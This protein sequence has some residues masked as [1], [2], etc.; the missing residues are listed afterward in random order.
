MV[1]IPA[2]PNSPAAHLAWK[3]ASG[4]NDLNPVLSIR[5]DG[6]LMQIEYRDETM[7]GGKSWLCVYAGGRVY[8][9]IHKRYAER[10]VTTGA[11]EDELRRRQLG[12]NPK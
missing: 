1:E 4:T 7:P 5:D 10:I 11:R 6:R 3:I 9:A 8:E 2:H 12:Q